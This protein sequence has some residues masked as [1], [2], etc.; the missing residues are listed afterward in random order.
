MCG[1]FEL[2]SILMWQFLV[3]CMSGVTIAGA[4]FVKKNLS[5]TQSLQVKFQGLWRKLQVKNMYVGVNCCGTIMSEVKMHNWSV[6]EICGVHRISL[7]WMP[8]V[9]YVPCE[10]IR[11]M[12]QW[13]LNKCICK[14]TDALHTMF[15]LY[16]QCKA[17]LCTDRMLQLCSGGWRLVLVWR[18]KHN[19]LV[20]SLI[21]SVKI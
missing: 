11:C 15:L 19:I 13:P 4:Q 12:S 9:K 21:Y 20:L 6:A 3:Y 5:C 18:V 14:I 1:K 10:N 8:C 7:V 17:G 16:F 2:H